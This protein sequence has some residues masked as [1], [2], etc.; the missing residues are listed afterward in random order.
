MSA[1]QTAAELNHALAR[2]LNEEAR[3]NPQSP[4]AG[5]FVGISSG[6][7]VAVGD[8]LDDV[9]ERLRQTGADPRES[10]CFEAGLGYSQVQEI[11][12]LH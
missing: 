2:K 3:V 10:L 9:I 11:W 8:D 7:V 5:K 12:R 1:F 6:Q 4:I